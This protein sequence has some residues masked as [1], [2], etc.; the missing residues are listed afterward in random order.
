LLVHRELN[1]VVV[2]MVNWLLPRDC[3]ILTPA[4]VQSYAH[5]L[6]TVTT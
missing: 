6:V 1:L 4:K 3:L 5:M 2:A